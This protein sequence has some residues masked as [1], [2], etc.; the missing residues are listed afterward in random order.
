MGC[1]CGSKG[2]RVAPLAPARRGWGHRGPALRGGCGLSSSRKAG[3]ANVPCETL[4]PLLWHPAGPGHGAAPVGWVPW[5]PAWGQPGLTATVTLWDTPS[6]AWRPQGSSALGSVLV[7][8]SR[9]SSVTW[10]TE[11]PAG[12]RVAVPGEGTVPW[13]FHRGR[14]LAPLALPM[15]WV[16]GCFGCAPTPPSPSPSLFSR[17]ALP[18]R[19]LHPHASGGASA[20]CPPPPPRVRV[21]PLSFPCHPHRRVLQDPRQFLHPGAGCWGLGQHRFLPA[22]PDELCV[23]V[24]VP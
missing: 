3:V 12:C 15:P 24:R 21:R 5:P 16:S 7:T 2:T 19:A 20:A 23:L 17:R 13:G 14:T 4:C 18:P 6:P 22:R 8:A 11:S 10:G 1:R 9:R